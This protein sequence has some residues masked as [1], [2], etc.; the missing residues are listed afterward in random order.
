MKCCITDLRNKDVISKT[1][2]A[3]LGNVVDCQ[4][5]TCTGCVEALVVVARPRMFGFVAREEFFVRW[6][7]IDIIGDDIILVSYTHHPAPEARKRGT[8]EGL[9]R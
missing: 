3:R 4:V 6:Q 5:D 8:M 1:T 7:D 2:G 9:F